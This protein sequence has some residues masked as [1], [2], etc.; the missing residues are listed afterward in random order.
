MCFGR[1]K[2]S[3][4]GGGGFSSAYMLVYLRK[5]DAKR[6][7][8]PVTDEDIPIS[9]VEHLDSEMLKKHVEEADRMVLKDMMKVSYFLAEDVAKFSAFNSSQMLVDTNSSREIGVLKSC[10]VLGLLM[11]FSK[12]FGKHLYEFRVWIM[13]I[14]DDDCGLRVV[15]DI[16]E[17][18]KRQQSSDGAF[19]KL[20]TEAD[21]L[22][23]CDIP[24]LY[25]E[26]NPEYTE[27]EERTLMS[28]F[29]SNL[30]KVQ[31]VIF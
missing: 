17:W 31:E 9:L 30:D 1:E 6:I 5:T 23:W 15:Y 25:I 12:L 28:H 4:Y 20:E 29:G 10:T 11:S 8:H 21:S 2:D 26:M 3:R 19:Y 16:F 14:D 24:Y 18:V 7:M 27:E 13:D 22:K